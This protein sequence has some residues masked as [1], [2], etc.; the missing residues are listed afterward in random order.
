M[1]NKIFDSVNSKDLVMTL[2]EWISQLPEDASIGKIKPGF[3]FC[4]ETNEIYL[5]K[6]L[7]DSDDTGN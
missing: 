7:K 6:D 1:N 5:Y 4:N 3:L 2:E